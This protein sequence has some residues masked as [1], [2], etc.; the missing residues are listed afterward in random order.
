MVTVEEKFLE[1]K[2]AKE[3]LEEMKAKYF[4]FKNYFEHLEKRTHFLTQKRIS[5]FGETV[6]GI[7]KAKEE[8]SKEY[9][10]TSEERD[11][12]FRL[13]NHTTVERALGV[14]PKK[15][16]IGVHVENAEE[17]KYLEFDF[18]DIAKLE[19]TVKPSDAKIAE[20]KAKIHKLNRTEERKALLHDVDVCQSLYEDLFWVYVKSLLYEQG[21]KIQEKFRLER[22]QEMKDKDSK[23]WKLHHLIFKTTPQHEGYFKPEEKDM[24]KIQAEKEFKILQTRY[25]ENAEK[26]LKQQKKLKEENKK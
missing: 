26:I 8:I 4:I 3:I 24:W 10:R 2:E 25:Y 19:E 16:V 6:E 21:F 17:K 14:D 5:T 1:T 18:A 9:E 23:M 7:H 15:I 13:L 12:L 11:R 20:L 22:M